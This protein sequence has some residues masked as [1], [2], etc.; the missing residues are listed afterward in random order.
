M[1]VNGK[2][3]YHIHTVNRFTRK[4]QPGRTIEFK[5]EE[6]NR[7]FASRFARLDDNIEA[8]KSSKYISENVKLFKKVE[9]FLTN[10]SPGFLDIFDF[11][12]DSQKNTLD[13]LIRAREMNQILASYNHLLNELIFEQVRHKN[14]PDLPS[15]LKCTWLC[16]RR[17]IKKWLSLF[18]SRGKRK[19]FEVQAFGEVFK[20]D[21]SWLTADVT[22]ATEIFRRAIEYWKG[23]LNPIVRERQVEYLFKGRL[24]VIDQIFLPAL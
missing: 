16:D 11:V 10:R 1:I 8:T 6:L 18:D 20:A 3:Y 24:K 9:K 15:R 21:R 5:G 17:N 19:I 22:T 2:I 13:L 12:R 23:S 4:W 7:I 14:Y